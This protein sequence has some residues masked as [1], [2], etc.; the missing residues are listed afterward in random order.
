MNKKK[1]KHTSTIQSYL[2]LLPQLIGFFVFGIYPILWVFRLA[3]F[4]YNGV[5][6]ARFVLFDNFIRLFTRDGA[7]WAS[8]V[9]T[10]I[11]SFGKLIIEIPLAL[12]LA[13]VLNHKLKGRHF[14]RTMFYMPN[15]ISV[16][17]IGLVF[18]FLF[19]TF[20]GIVNNTLLNFD[21]IARPVNWFGYKWTA[22]FVIAFAS[23]WQ[24]FGVN[25]LFF[26]AGLQNIP[27]ELY[28]AASIDGA[29]KFQ[30]FRKVTLPLL[31]PT[32]QIVLMLAILGSIKVTDLVLVLTNGMPAGQTEVVMTYIFKR[33]FSYNGTSIPD[34]GYASAMGMITAIILAIITGIYLKIT[35]K[36]NKIY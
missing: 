10:L 12:I 15:V 21:L 16:A 8:L 14:F 29:S 5:S 34:I 6:E 24:N 36:M 19:S 35:K 2:M 30:Q 4:E 1:K 25:M 28:E 27:T 20:E 23:I 9:N 13:V 18:S 7:Y 26:L 17:I 33:F 3:W 11:L 31:A 32:L 22:M